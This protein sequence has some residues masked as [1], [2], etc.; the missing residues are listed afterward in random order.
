MITFL[1]GLSVWAVLVGAFIVLSAS[2]LGMKMVDHLLEGH[3]K[4]QKEEEG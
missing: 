1:E 3:E 2:I 4:S